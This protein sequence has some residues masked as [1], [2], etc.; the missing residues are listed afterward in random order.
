MRKKLTAEEL[1]LSVDRFERQFGR[2]YDINIHNPENILPGRGIYTSNH[3]HHFDP[4]FILYAIARFREVLAH[5]LAKP[6]LFRLP[7]IGRLLKRYQAVVTPR[8][9]Q[10]ES[11]DFEDYDRMKEEI[12][13]VMEK[14]EPLSYAY[15]ARMTRNHQLD[16]ESAA[17]EAGTATS[18]PLT[19]VRKHR[20]LQLVP[21][22]VEVY[23]KRSPKLVAGA[24]L[25]LSGIRS[26]FPVRKKH[27]VDVI[28]GEPVDIDEFL[29]REKPGTGKR[30]GRQDL[31]T[32]A[33]EQVYELRRMLAR[34]NER[35]P[36]RSLDRCLQ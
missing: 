9:S 10:G 18:G 30:N 28:F 22:A 33:V 34:K 6:D 29:S 5:Q 19:L 35:D 15:A 32:H 23:Q 3:F 17:R 2:L 25:T 31:I 26:W 8:P 27:A 4:I 13:T 36:L 14:D 1:R 24:A 12:E 16:E 20:G 21:V 7:V 11:F